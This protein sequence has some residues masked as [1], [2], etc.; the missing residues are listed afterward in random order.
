MPK[1]PRPPLWIR[2]ALAAFCLLLLPFLLP[3]CR[4][5]P[6]AMN[7]PPEPAPA[8][9]IEA[10]HLID[11][12]SEVRGVWIASVWNLDYPSRTDL[13]AEEL[14]AELDAILETCADCGLNTVFFQ[15]RPAADALY[16]SDLFPVSSALS[17]RGEL[18]F[19]PLRYLVNTAR[20]RNI[21]VFAWVNPLR[22]T[23]IG[24]DISALPDGH[25]AK[26]H[27]EWTVPYADG[28]LYFN[29]GLPEVRR[30]VADGVRE[31]V[32]RYDVDGIVFDDYFYP[33][34]A[35]GEDGKRADFDDGEAYRLYGG[36]FDDV[37]DWRRDN[38]NRMI[39]ECSEV[40]H[41][42]DPE[43]LFGVSPY[44]VWQNSDG[45]NGG[46]DTNSFEAY[47]YLYCD[48]TAWIDAGTVD[49]ISP[50]IYWDFESDQAPFDTL[51]RWWND[52]LDGSGVKLWVSHACYKYDEPD[53]PDPTGQLNEQ[54]TFAR[55]ERSYYGSILY[56]Y[57]E[58][59]RNARGAA[60]DTKR[61]FS[62]EII[63]SAT[64]SN[65][66]GVSVSSPESGTVLDSPETYIMG[67]SDPYYP[68]TM[69]GKKVG[70]TKSGYFSLTVTLEN[71]ENTF[72]FE[73]NG[74]RYTYTLWYGRKTGEVGE[75]EISEEPADP[76]A[77]KED[78]T[79]LGS[80]TIPWT[81]PSS[82][83][84]T[85]E[86]TL[87]VSC[88]APADSDVTADLGGIVT[89]LVPLSDPK[90]RKTDDGWVYVAYGASVKLPEAG[91]NILLDCFSVQFT[92]IHP[93][94]PEPMTAEGVRVRVLGEN[95]GVPVTVL[96]DSTPL[97]ISRN[98]SYYND[99]TVQ[100]A[101]M[102]DLAVELRDGYYRL[103]MGG[104]VAAEDVEE[105]EL[106]HW[107]DPISEDVPPEEDAPDKPAPDPEDETENAA[108]EEEKA[109]PVKAEEA[110]GEDKSGGEKTEDN[111]GGDE[112]E[113]EPAEEEKPLPE[114]KT[115]ANKYLAGERVSAAPVISAEAVN[116]GRVTEAVFHFADSDRPAPLFTNLLPKSRP[117]YNASV[118]DGAF[119]LTLYSVDGQNCADLDFGDNPLF[120]G[121]ETVRLDDRVRYVFRLYDAANFYGFDLAY[122][123]EGA[124]MAAVLTLKNPI[125]VDFESERPLKGIRLVLDAGHGGSDPGAFGPVRAGAS[126]ASSDG[127]T[128][129]GFSNSEKDVNLNLTLA[130]A[131]KLRDLGA[132]VI[133]LRGEDETFD[134]LARAAALESLAPDLAVSLHQNSMGYT[135]DIT[136][137]RGTLGL[138]CQAGGWLLADSVGRSVA[139]SL[140]RA[141][142]ETR[143]QALAMCRCQKFPSAL[144]EVGFMTNV[145]EYEFMTSARGI[146]LGAQGVADGIL[147]YFRRVARFAAG[148]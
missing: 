137:I 121:C 5:V 12:D 29:A 73:Q 122:R 148:E 90:T 46:S 104:Y 22:A 143:W 21:R 119:V 64:L 42:I 84:M 127:G 67:L 100:S 25:P 103:R 140:D 111:S 129:P 35:N 9:M 30:L 44:G 124:G 1:N 45:K 118:E 18:T 69:D 40:T 145:E 85:S 52:R 8:P 58:L 70:R 89:R 132:E 62:P 87:W 53:W 63:Y 17:S 117:P 86:E 114:S 10:G 115:F 126:L 113:E 14:Q 3:S 105:A 88:T 97:K 41:F 147:A 98:S 32:T 76:D 50:Q 142:R 75:T 101:G 135:A 83:V 108:P 59:K 112:P 4:K 102:T 116:L 120:D 136:K 61:A 55:A 80:L 6:P 81:Y 48:A 56:G 94:S 33:Y 65:G 37:A 95:A 92:A 43:C 36:D 93:D 26:A 133:L 131:E 82:E 107:D 2:T 110:E 34:P 16:E 79:V 106:E 11:P 78:L 28:K 68:L 139:S 60:D 99:Y 27:P 7:I 144:I 19:D 74:R 138:W 15:V 96:K 31:I 109:P 128:V 72:V 146:E 57:D 24:T 23:L 66:L 123:E 77:E 125:A 51:L 54:I 71:G 91:R 39:A 47:K 141:Y 20:P 13:S 49:F 38:V 130:A 134:L